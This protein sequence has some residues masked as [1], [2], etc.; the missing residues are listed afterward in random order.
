[1]KQL[2]R[3]VHADHKTAAAQVSP[4]RA[5]TDLITF[6]DFLERVAGEGD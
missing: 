6:A 3:E 5:R 1:M 2:E 4:E